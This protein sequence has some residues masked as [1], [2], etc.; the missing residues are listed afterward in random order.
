MPDKSSL[1]RKP[2]LAGLAFRIGK[3]SRFWGW[4]APAD[5][6]SSLA[7]LS[8]D[9]DMAPAGWSNVAQWLKRMHAQA[10]S[11]PDTLPPREE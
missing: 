9:A 8:Q 6:P 11:H 4:G 3:Y 5:G 1:L 7:V 10:D 2:A